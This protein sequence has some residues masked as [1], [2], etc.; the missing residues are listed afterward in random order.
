VICAKGENKK[1][2]PSFIQIDNEKGL[3]FSSNSVAWK[4]R[5]AERDL[6]KALYEEHFGEATPERTKPDR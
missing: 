5:K 1:I 2:V 3:F 4:H 6:L